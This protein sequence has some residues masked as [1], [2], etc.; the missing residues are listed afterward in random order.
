MP[1]LHRLRQMPRSDPG[2]AGSDR[3]AGASFVIF[4]EYAGYPADDSGYRN[5]YHC[6][7]AL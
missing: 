7:A 4:T 2:D 5:D 6:N 3:K 1:D